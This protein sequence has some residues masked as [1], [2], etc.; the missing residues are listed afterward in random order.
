MKWCLNKWMCFPSM[1]NIFLTTNNNTI[2]FFA[3]NPHK[4]SI[5]W[6]HS[7]S[8]YYFFSTATTLYFANIISYYYIYFSYY[9]F[10]SYYSHFTT[11]PSIA[12]TSTIT[13]T[14]A[15]T[16]AKWTT[17]GAKQKSLKKQKG[18]FL[19]CLVG[20]LVVFFLQN[21][22]AL[23][24]SQCDSVR[25]FMCCNLTCSSSRS[26]SSHCVIEKRDVRIMWRPGLAG[27][28]LWCD[29]CRQTRQPR[30]LTRLTAA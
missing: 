1:K 13:L 11:I 21:T 3:I 4:T 6:M 26:S 25:L 14:S 7:S 8:C 2:E 27:S 20:W 17:S 15:V 30:R 5:S 29:E 9:Y 10:H 28:A 24:K 19:V 18:F 23:S 12:L 22:G 16:S